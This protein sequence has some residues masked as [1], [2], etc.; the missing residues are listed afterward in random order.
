MVGGIRGVPCLC[1][2]LGTGICLTTE[3][4]HG[5][6]S[7]RAPAKSLPYRRRARFVWSNWPSTSGGLDWSVGT[8]RRRFELL[9]KEPTLGQSRY[10]P[11]CRSKG[12]PSSAIFESK[13]AVRA[14]WSANSG[15]SKSSCIC[16]LLR[17]Q[18]APVTRR[19]HL[20]CR[21]CGL[22]TCV[23]QRTSQMGTRNPSFG[24]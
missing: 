8:R 2:D 14:L 5:K 1:I 18:G 15:T 19:K 9:A 12:F 11:C 3:E 17:Y 24:G 10:L 22:L 13:L 7:V 6:T 16:L 20:D 4:N 21:T 23:G